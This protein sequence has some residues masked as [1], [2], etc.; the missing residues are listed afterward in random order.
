M[1]PR[2]FISRTCEEY[3][4]PLLPCRKAGAIRVAAVCILISLLLSN[5]IQDSAFAFSRT[6]CWSVFQRVPVFPLP[7]HL[8]H[9]LN[10]PGEG[11]NNN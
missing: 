1:V 2:T 5:F 3:D 4:A 11:V 6:T 9:Q 10:Q 7:R 8:G